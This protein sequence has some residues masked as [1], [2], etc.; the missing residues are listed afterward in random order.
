MCVCVCVCVCLYM[1]V[2]VCL[3]VCVWEWVSVSLCV[4]GYDRTARRAPEAEEPCGW[5]WAQVDSARW[6]APVPAGGN[7]CPTRPRA[8][9]YLPDT[10]TWRCLKL[11]TQG[12][13]ARTDGLVSLTV[14]RDVEELGEVRETAVLLQMPVNQAAGVLQSLLKNCSWTAGA[15]TGRHDHWRLQPPER[16]EQ[17]SISKIF[18]YVNNNSYIYNWILLYVC[19]YTHT[20]THTS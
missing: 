2:C 3:Y 9:A 20:H 18:I 6:S 12:L 19:I 11:N 4:V 8:K 5:R 10:S 7:P 16:E 15:H 17:Y 14:W 1:C 13:T